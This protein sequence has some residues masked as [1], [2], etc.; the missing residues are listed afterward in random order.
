MVF[1]ILGQNKTKYFEE[2]ENFFFISRL[3]KFREF[4]DG[5]FPDEFCKYR[6]TIWGENV[7]INFEN[8]CLQNF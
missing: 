2:Y 5:A 4:P 3:T 6:F 7:R 8:L 1:V